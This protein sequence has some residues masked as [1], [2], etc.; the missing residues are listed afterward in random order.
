M[1]SSPC[2]GADGGSPPPVCTY[3]IARHGLLHAPTHSAALSLYFVIL[4]LLLDITALVLYLVYRPSK[5]CFAVVFAAIYTLTHLWHH[6]HHIADV[7]VTA[8]VGR[9]NMVVMSLVIDGVS[10]P[11]SSGL[12]ADQAYGTVALWLVVVGWLRVS[13]GESGAGG[14]GAPK[15]VMFNKQIMYAET[16]EAT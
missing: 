2:N 16:V 14:N 13:M 15:L 4:V 9:D 7:V 8:G 10:V 11:L 5:P 12:A 3:A 6:Y 1:I